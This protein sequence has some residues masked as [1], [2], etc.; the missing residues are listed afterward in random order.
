MNAD[1]RRFIVRAY[2]AYISLFFSAAPCKNQEVSPQSAQSSQ[3]EGGAGGEE[4]GWGRGST[5]RRV[6]LLLSMR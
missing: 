4:E 2:I 1:E 5:G 3:R 6:A